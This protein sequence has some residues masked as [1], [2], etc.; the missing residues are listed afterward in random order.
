MKYKGRWTVDLK[1]E[2][3]FLPVFIGTQGD[4]IK[5]FEGLVKHIGRFDLVQ[6][7]ERK[8]IGDVIRAFFGDGKGG[9]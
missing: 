9:G 8:P 5:V 3:E 1:I 6:S 2:P 7:I 4:C